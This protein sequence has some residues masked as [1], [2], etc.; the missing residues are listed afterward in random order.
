MDL[1]DRH[2]DFVAALRR[3]GIQVSVAEDIDAANALG[4][5]DMT[6]RDQLRAAYAA[7]A[8]KRPAHRPA[9]DTV[10]DLYFPAL[11]DD[12]GS[13][14][15]E[16]AER[17]TPGR[18]IYPGDP[19]LVQFREQLAQQLLAGDADGLAQLARVGVGRFGAVTGGAPGVQSWSAYITMARTSPD[20]LLAALLEQALLPDER[21]TMAERLMRQTFAA[22]IAA[23]RR[24]VD[25]EVQRRLAAESGPDRVARTAVRPSAER[26][27]LLH[28]TNA[29]LSAIRREVQPLA[30]RLAARLAY[31]HRHGRRGKLDF[32]RTIRASLS[33]GGVPMQTHMRP[34]HPRKTDLVILCDVSDSVTSFARFT[35]ML[36]FALR[37]QFSRV[38]VFAFVDDLDEVTRFF[39]PGVDIVE[40]VTRLDAEAKVRGWYGRTDYG[41]A[42]RLF[43]EMHSDAIAARTSL[44]VLGD[45]RS[46][47]GDP[48]VP[49]LQRLAGRARRAYWLNPERRGAWDTGDSC[50]S[51][52]G[53]VMPMVECRNL[54][55]LAD[56]VRDVV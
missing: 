11:L 47:Y 32:R 16:A 56:F 40:A 33:S 52:V 1:F 48:N 12:A 31:D 29:D 14:A 2:L 49:A 35:L 24:L 34:R 39:R 10:F 38:R 46:N 5:I 30:R 4:A 9:F 36:V 53:R 19:T 54:S 26:L 44:L 22:R 55:Q 27:D 18:Q 17:A 37:E 3:A 23:F 21:G 42:F 25:T 41:R 43:E 15:E 7:A 51:Q 28:A 50:A 20:T 45:A 8:V 13:A 6:D